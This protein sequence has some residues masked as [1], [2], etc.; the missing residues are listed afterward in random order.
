LSNRRI[1][2]VT[3]KYSKNGVYQVSHTIC[4]KSVKIRSK[5]RFGI[6]KVTD[7]EDRFM[8]A[9]D[10]RCASCRRRVTLTYKTYAAYDKAVPVCPNCGGQEL[11]R[12]IGRVAI[13]KSEARRFGDAADDSAL[14]DLAE[15]DPTTLGRYM[16][17]LGAESGEDL[18]DEF[19]EVVDRLEKGESPES[20]EATMDIPGDVGDMGGGADLSGMGALGGMGD[21]AGMGGD[22]G[23]SFGDE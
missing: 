2:Y 17:R 21:M 12:V 16:R 3:Q 18:G 13:A 19:N 20:I 5:Y 14:D 10:Y 8:P 6:Y 1:V 11:T 15:A 7:I 23:S 22:F 9:Y 4:H